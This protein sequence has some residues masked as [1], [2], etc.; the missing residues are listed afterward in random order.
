MTNGDKLLGKF[1]EGT[2]K[3]VPFDINWMDLFILHVE[4]LVIVRNGKKRTTANF[5]GLSEHMD[6]ERYGEKLEWYEIPANA[7][8]GFG[9]V[10]DKVEV[11]GK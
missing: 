3:V 8:R 9:E 4:K 5:C 10:F 1:G 6:K 2:F 7:I 11:L